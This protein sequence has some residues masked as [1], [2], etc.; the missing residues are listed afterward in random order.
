MSLYVSAISRDIML[1][2]GDRNSAPVASDC[3]RLA[4]WSLV[5]PESAPLCEMRSTFV[6]A[7]WR[8][9]SSLV[10]LRGATA[11]CSTYALALSQEDMSIHYF[12]YVVV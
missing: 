11:F 1:L 12:W 10:V 8:P 4:K 3:Q 7:V 2:V 5:G 6:R 9:S